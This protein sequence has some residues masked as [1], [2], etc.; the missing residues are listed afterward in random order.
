MVKSIKINEFQGSSLMLR[1]LTDRFQSVYVKYFLGFILLIFLN[2]SNKIHAQTCNCHV[3]FPLGNQYWSQ[4]GIGGNGYSVDLLICVYGTL[5]MDVD[6]EKFLN[7]YFHMYPGSSIVIPSGKHINFTGNRFERCNNAMWNGMKVE[8]GGEVFLYQNTFN[9]AIVALDLAPNSTI[10]VFT[11]NNFNRCKEG[12]YADKAIAKRDFLENKFYSNGMLIAP[13]AGQFP[14]FGMRLKGMVVN[15]VRGSYDRM[16][17]RAI[18][19]IDNS[20]YVGNGL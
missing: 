18:N 11:Q 13:F 7:C 15:E 17:R 16:M 5:Y 9:D 8:A 1:S 14:D 10:T 3:T 6:N 19:I 20:V 12:V 4:S 2:F